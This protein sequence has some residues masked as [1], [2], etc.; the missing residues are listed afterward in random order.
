MELKTGIKGEASEIV[1]E[2]KTASYVGSGLVEV[3]ATP[4]LLALLEKAA[5]NALEPFLQ[6][7]EASVGIKV[8]FAHLKATPI[9]MRVKAFAE[10]SAIEG[11][12]LIWKIEAYDE[13]DKIAEG[14]HERFI[15]QREKFLAEANKKLKNSYEIKG[16]NQ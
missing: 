1:T 4:C 11:R 14:I 6:E 16:D 10:L 13:L 3:Y 8:N 12:K 2:E 5:V 15:V 7:E 9:G